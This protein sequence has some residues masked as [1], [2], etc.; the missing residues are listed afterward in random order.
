MSYW[1]M[2]YS[3]LLRH[4]V[5]IRSG[6]D[7]LFINLPYAMPLLIMGQYLERKC[8]AQKKQMTLAC[9][10]PLTEKLLVRIGE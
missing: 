5:I 3:P 10:G 9:I 2:S 8:H 7:R 4:N 6:Y 1:L